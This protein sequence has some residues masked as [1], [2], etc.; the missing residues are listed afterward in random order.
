MTAK[1]RATVPNHNLIGNTAKERVAAIVVAAGGSIRMGGIDKIFTNLGGK[2]LVAYVLSVFDA[3]PCVDEVVLVVSRNNLE[4]AWNLVQASGWHK[5]THICP[6]GSRRQDSVR[7]GLEQVGNVPWV[8][9]HDGA[10]PF[11]TAKLV[12]DG[13]LAARDTGA[14]VAA[15]PVKETIKIVNADNSVRL[16]PHKESLWVAQTPQIFRTELLLAAYHDAYG[17]VTDE[18]TLLE[19]QGK[20]VRVYMGDP[21][22]IKITTPED[23]ELAEWMVE[24]RKGLA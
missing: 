3:C 13:L 11:V 18:A 1:A 20:T 17:D 15:V 12:E 21:N 5:V 16:T 19:R 9:I 22:N 7:L 23:L 8:V 2:P 24:K 4:K 10:R 6:G 14:A